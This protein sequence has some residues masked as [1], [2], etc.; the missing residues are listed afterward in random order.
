VGEK[1]EVLIPDSRKSMRYRGVQCLNCGHPLELSDRFCSYCGQLNSVKRLSL[2]DFFGEFL[3][4]IFT[5]DSRFRYTV[6]DIIFKPGTI[7]RN[8]VN[9]KRLKYANPFR[10]FLSISIL[11]FLLAN[12]FSYLNPDS[13]A[14]NFGKLNLFKNDDVLIAL[15][16]KD[17]EDSIP[18]DYATIQHNNYFDYTQ[19]SAVDTMD[20]L[21]GLKT[22]YTL[23][24]SYYYATETVDPIEALDSLRYESTPFNRWMYERNAV[25]ER[26]DKNPGLFINYLLNKLPFFIFFLTPVVALSFLLIYFKRRSYGEIKSSLKDYNNKAWQY[27]LGIPILGYITLHLCTMTIKFFWVKRPVNYMEHMIFIFHIFTFLFLGLFLL[28]LPDYLLGE[29]YLSGIF[30]TLICPFYLYKALRNF[31]KE[32]RIR[33]LIKFFTIHIIFGIIS[34]IL[35]SCFLMFTAVSYG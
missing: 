32:S 21:Q 31:Y 23:F 11:Y 7:T 24:S 8:Y 20:Y 27:L 22:K 13:A 5:Y 15:K 14:R 6:K 1:E 2:K 4:S 34:I 18:L 25:F 12:L 10:F 29:D 16:Y 28:L 9:G 19:E 35:G 26:I 30:I 17:V 33:T 3:H